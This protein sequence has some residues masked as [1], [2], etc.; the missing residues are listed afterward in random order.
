MKNAWIPVGVLWL[1]AACQSLPTHAFLQADLAGILGIVERSVGQPGPYEDPYQGPAFSNATPHT[2]VWTWSGELGEVMANGW[3]TDESLY[4]RLTGLD[5]LASDADVSG[6]LL[7]FENL[8]LSL[9][10]AM[11]LSR[12]LRAVAA[13]GK[14]VSCHAQSATNVSYVLM[15]A[16]NSVALAPSGTLV[17]SGPAAVP[18]H[19]RGLFDR[20]GIVPDFLHVGDFKTGPEPFTQTAPSSAARKVTNAL[21]D[22]AYSA[23]VDAI[24]E[25]RRKD[26]AIVRTWIDAALW[27]AND[28]RAAG[29]IDAVEPYETFR[30]RVSNGAWKK[31]E[32]PDSAVSDLLQFIGMRPPANA[33]GE[34]VVIVNAVGSIVDG[35]GNGIAGATDEIAAGTLV[36][37]LRAL[38]NNADVKA[39]V[40]RIDS[41]GGSAIASEQLWHAMSELVAHKP[42][43]VS[44]SD[45]AAS[46]G[47]YM[48]APAT[49]IFAEPTTLTGSIGVFGGKLALSRALSNW[50]VK[51]YPV[52]RGKRATMNVGLA[53]WN[54][55]E[56]RIIQKNLLATYDLFLTR[57]AEGRRLS[58]EAVARVASGRVWTGQ[59]A[60]ANGLVDDL[61]GLHAALA[62]ARELGGVAADADVETYPPRPT[63][64]DLLVGFDGMGAL[65]TTTL[66]A[67]DRAP[68]N[69]LP[70]AFRA[71]AIEALRGD[72]SRMYVWAEAS[73]PALRW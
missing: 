45:V 61:G 21:L 38:T 25:G 42:V 54:A 40:L 13:K 55:D 52:G 39:V 5:E 24:S 12:A 47:Y 17:I 9:P 67:A 32:T 4:A 15:T 53:P 16:C 6:L 36:P 69:V 41:G 28:A 58:K 44:M 3:S 71:A 35:E 72:M 33:S 2:V 43:V 29:L 62:H 37:A 63:L 57:V 68:W 70:R 31:R 20:F 14:S 64:R 30:E 8:R 50:G 46:G 66:M 1:T 19:F 7:R 60:K 59:E 48:A 65:A 23:M 51:T 26:P 73:L 49:K 56:R 27:S 18:M 34:R 22:N 11:E 10:D